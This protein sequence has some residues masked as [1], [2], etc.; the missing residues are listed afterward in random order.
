MRGTRLPVTP[1]TF[2]YSQF[3]LRL[4]CCDFYW[5]R[6]YIPWLQAQ[7][8]VCRMAFTQNTQQNAAKES[9]VTGSHTVEVDASSQEDGING[10]RYDVT[11]MDRMG[12]TQQFK[13]D[14]QLPDNT[15]QLTNRIAAKHPVFC[16]PQFFG[17]IAVYVGVHHAV[18][19]PE[20]SL[21][22]SGSKH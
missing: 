18:R 11:E 20:F 14:M 8:E 22:P 4:R 15:A 17:R 5:S 9:V 6:L 10:T 13:V 16:R 1:C 2:S 12:K 19:Q 3:F 21:L 7:S